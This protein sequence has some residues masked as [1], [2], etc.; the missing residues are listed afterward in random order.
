MIMTNPALDNAITLVAVFQPELRSG[1]GL[2]MSCALAGALARSNAAA[3]KSEAS[4]EIRREEIR[5]TNNG[6]TSG[7]TLS[8]A[9]PA[10]QLDRT[11]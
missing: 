10:S 11:G 5:F 3:T 1:V 2:I 6:R 8:A 4:S 9:G 7:A